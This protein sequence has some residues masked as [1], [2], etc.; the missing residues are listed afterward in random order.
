MTITYKKELLY[1]SHWVVTLI[2][3]EVVHDAEEVE[4]SL[5][6]K[7]CATA[8]WSPGPAGPGNPTTANGHTAKRKRTD[9][10]GKTK[11]D[12]QVFV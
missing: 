12:I 9:T 10:H 5:E 4:E 7:F 2:S 8:E 11:N 6:D 1:R 3:G